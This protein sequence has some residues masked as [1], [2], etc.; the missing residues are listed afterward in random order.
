VTL[1]ETLQGLIKRTRNEPRRA[2]YEAVLRCPPLPAALEY[3]W[4]V[5]CR[6][7]ARRG[8][9]GFSI[10][11]ISWAEIEAF[12]RLTGVSLAPWEVRLIEELDDM[13][14]SSIQRQD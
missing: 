11:P 5:F 8:G 9:T 6:L 2:E 12:T 4:S 10:S 1:R 7:S 13:F 14:R 3:L